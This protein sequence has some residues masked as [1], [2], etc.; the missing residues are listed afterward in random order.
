MNSIK[1]IKDSEN[2]KKVVENMRNLSNT[3]NGIENI[4]SSIIETK[5]IKIKALSYDKIMFLKGEK[6]TAFN[7]KRFL[8]V[9]QQAA[10]YWVRKYKGKEFSSLI[11]DLIL[12]GWI[13]Q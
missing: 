9:S 13:I 6:V 11:L 7:V 4:D 10:N 1:S 8:N 5:P 3:L 2:Y 12:K